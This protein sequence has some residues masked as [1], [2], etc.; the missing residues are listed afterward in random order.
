MR[1][2]LVLFL[3]LSLGF[4]SCKKFLNTDPSDFLTQEEY[5]NTESKLMSALAG[6]YQ[7]LG[8]AGLYGDNMFDQ[9]GAA[10]DEGFYARSA[11]TT[12][13]MVYNFDYTNAN[14]ADFWNQLYIGIE[15]ANILI[16]NINVASLDERKREAILGEVMFLRGYYHFLL[17]SNF[18][19][20]PLKTEPT[21]SVSAVYVSRNPAKEVYAQ[22]LAD[23]EA[24]ESK[25]FTATELGYGGRISKT[26]VEGILARVCLTMA[27]FPL[28]DESKYA[29]A[30]K[31]A[32]LV[33]QSGEHRLN[34]S[35]RQVFINVHHDLYDVRESMWEVENKGTG[36]DGYGNANRL[37]NT[38]GIVATADAVA[39]VV[40]YSYG[41]INT[42]AKL[43]N[44]YSSGDLR[45]DWNIAPY[46]YGY[47]TAAASVY[48]NYLVASNIYGRNAGKWRREY[49]LTATKSKN[50][51]PLNFSVLR[52][53]D[54]LLMLAEAE[55]HVNGPTEIAYDAINQ[56]RR[57]AFGFDPATAVS[58][59]SVVS[60]LTL[61]GTGNTGYLT[62][63][64]NNLPVNI[65]GGGGT[66]AAGEAL[67]VYSA[68][69]ASAKVTV[70]SL[71]SPGTGYT[72]VPAVTVGTAWAANTTYTSGTQVFSGNN[73]YTV[74]TAGTST[75]TAP[76]QTAG[77]SA[78][79]VTGAVFT[80]AGLRATA[81]AVI[82]TSAVDLAGLSQTSFQQAVEDERARELCYETQR[83]PD[84]IRWGKWVST[85]NGLAADMKASA[86]TY[87][88][89][90]AGG[91][92]ITDRT[93]L[94]PI[95]SSEVSVN[96]NTTQNPGW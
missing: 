68:T 29:D 42:T 4:T 40:G 25:V 59:V 81:T 50:I 91:A 64:K 66:G 44:L 92:N 43:Y 52:Y 35:Y 62:A 65:T 10:T 24:A 3:L 71:T 53:S 31:W 12:G 94:Y 90:A 89:G 79:A 93:L 7:P 80:Y 69:A 2:T 30:L 19:D 95:P 84:L 83:R 14:L 28:K 6:V 39:A 58:S 16:K 41:F 11:Q 75:A 48:K 20:V 78:A 60:G 67:V 77:A 88:Y 13:T 61:S 37:G 55:N 57:R 49:E 63:G 15:R 70:L 87:A 21:P 27:G 36:A 9:L 22:V 38:N 54:V 86:G 85:M 46:T 26:A 34:S 17:V 56:V 76:V 51:T 32:T 96:K 23:M 5:Y 18:G 82:S 33:K 45:R 72:S 73:L 1:H 74:T 47:N 8:T